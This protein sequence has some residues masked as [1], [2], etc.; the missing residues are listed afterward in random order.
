M[1]QCGNKHSIVVQIYIYIVGNEILKYEH[2]ENLE[3]WKI[4][5]ILKHWTS[6]CE[7]V[8]IIEIPKV[9]RL[10]MG[11]LPCEMT[12]KHE[13]GQPEIIIG[14]LYSALKIHGFIL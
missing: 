5:I 2:V 6:K 8:D 10:Q 12:K 11:H 1:I 7:N 4:W 14:N 3:I 13:M 9:S